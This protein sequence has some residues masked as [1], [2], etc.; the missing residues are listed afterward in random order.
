GVS[1]NSAIASGI[2][3]VGP[4]VV[5]PPSDTST[6]LPAM[7]QLV[8]DKTAGTPSGNSAGSTIAYQFTVTNT[9]NLTLTGIV[10]NDPQLD[11]PA[12]CLLTTLIPGASTSCTGAHTLPQAEVDAGVSVN[13][14]T[15]TGTPP[16]GPTVVSP[17]DDT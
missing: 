14:A 2:P 9:G 1:V 3:P 17:P 5:S 15:A 12:V 10:D 4:P 8:I 7:P 16:S 6:P 11:A 13:S